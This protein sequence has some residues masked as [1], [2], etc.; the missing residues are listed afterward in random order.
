ML[1]VEFI[2]TG[3]GI[4][5]VSAAVSDN[6][7]EK[8]LEQYDQETELQLDYED[9]DEVGEVEYDFG[10]VESAQKS[11]SDSDVGFASDEQI[12]DVSTGDDFG[13]LGQFTD[14]QVTNN[15]AEDD[16]FG[17]GEE[18]EEF[19]TGDDLA[20]LGGENQVYI[21]EAEE[22]QDIT[23]SLNELLL[24]AKEVATDT[25]PCKVVI[26]Q[27]NYELSG[28][29]C[30]Y[31]N[32]YLY[33]E[34]ATIKKISPQKQI[35][36]RLG[37]TQ[38]SAGGYEGYRNITIEGG[39]WDCNYESV[40]DKEGP[41]GFV[42]FRIGHA[43]NVTIK[44]VTFLNNLKSH[45]LEFG[46][47]K[48]AS[49]TGCTFRGYWKGYDD[50]GQECIQ[51]DSCKDRIFPGYL[52]YDGS[53]CE[54][55]EI[56]NNVFEDVFAGVGSHSMMFDRPYRNITISNNTFKNITKRA[57][58]CLNYVD[59]IVSDNKMNNVGGGVYVRS[60]HEKNTHLSDGQNATN[61]GN[62]Q[63]ENVVVSNN[64]ISVSNT[65]QTSKGLWRSFGISVTGAVA[66]GETEVPKG[67]Y[68]V[69]GITVTGNKITGKG[70]GIYA[71]YTQNCVFTNNVVNVSRNTEAANL[72]FSLRKSSN[73]K[74]QGN[75]IR[76][77][78][79]PG[80][81]INGTSG[82]K[83]AHRI[84]YNT[85]TS[86]VADGIYARSAAAGLKISKNT[87]SGNR[88]NGIVTVSVPQAWLEQNK[89]TGNQKNGIYI[90]QCQNIQINKNSCSSNKK[91]GIY[92]LKST[93]MTV[94]QNTLKKNRSY[95]LCC[96][97]SYIKKYTG[98]KLAGNRTNKVYQKKSTIKGLK[99]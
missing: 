52:P 59:S 58:W 6:T 51:I 63:T 43:S 68:M 10:V 85:I 65:R 2:G 15:L 66:A 48:N 75:T 44:N 13:D 95:G 23:E 87:V 7:L 77:K 78:N 74:L 21:L 24:K 32:I 1:A 94:V 8:E 83:R 46:G 35:L 26:P 86:N 14:E 20:D 5:D 54:D 49:V 81:Y 22:G 70:H 73:D 34:G 98:N 31:S 88:G 19:S 67:T 60:V 41:G 42:G 29:I 47:I 82:T 27:G 12:P 69:K 56:R 93:K 38:E 62:Q 16:E 61:K 17:D 18:K 96:N 72:A 30:T 97:G 45:F 92:I 90:Q 55:I 37:N 9:E 4:T 36:L 79:G 80:L 84:Y 89:V 53:V 57:V 91:A 28:T 39:T 50:G 99:K 11:F 33:A 3:E 76:G 25:H 71:N 64:T 40:E